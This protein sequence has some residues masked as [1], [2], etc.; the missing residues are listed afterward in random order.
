MSIDVLWSHDSNPV[1]SCAN[2]ESQ[3]FFPVVDCHVGLYFI[4]ELNSELVSFML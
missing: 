2:S 3:A 4:I 1:P